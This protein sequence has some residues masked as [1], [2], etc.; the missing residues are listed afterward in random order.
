[1]KKRKTLNFDYEHPLWKMKDK[2]Y[3]MYE[4]VAA[5]LYENKG[6]LMHEDKFHEAGVHLLKAFNI[7]IEYGEDEIKQ[8]LYKKEREINGEEETV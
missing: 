2:S 4:T 1:M 5:Y 8:Q 7:L 3:E 6:K